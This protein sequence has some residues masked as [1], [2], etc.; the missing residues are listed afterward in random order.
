MCVVFSNIHYHSFYV[1]H[2]FSICCKDILYVSSAV[3]EYDIHI[4]CIICYPI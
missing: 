2:M 4:I 1:C 3:N